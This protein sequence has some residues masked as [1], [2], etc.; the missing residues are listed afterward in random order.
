[1]AWHLVKHRN[2]TFTCH[3]YYTSYPGENESQNSM[4]LH[5]SEN[6]LRLAMTGWE[7]Y[8]CIVSQYVTEYFFPQGIHA[9]I[10]P[11]CERGVFISL[12]C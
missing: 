7:I 2:V 11:P 5:D 3:K 12:V 9:S 10:S 8:R 4:S 6:V 1:M